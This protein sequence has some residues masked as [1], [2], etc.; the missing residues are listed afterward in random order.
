MQRDYTWF[1]VAIIS[2]M[3][4]VV[5]NIVYPNRRGVLGFIS[6]A[7]I[8][9]FCGGV[10]GMSAHALELHN[11]W[12]YVISASVAVL[13]DRV[14]TFVLCRRERQTT[15][16]YINGGQNAFGNNEIEMNHKEEDR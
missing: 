12:V 9:I 16:N 2:F 3:A 7:V 4:G 14:L 8:G 5:A 11:S 13:G 10:S 1:A 15:N 6:A